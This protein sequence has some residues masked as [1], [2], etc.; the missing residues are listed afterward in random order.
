MILDFYKKIYFFI[1]VIYFSILLKNN[2]L[3][4]AEY[5]FYHLQKIVK[6]NQNVIDVGANIGRYSFKLSKLVGK[7][8][9]VYAFEPMNKSFLT[10]LALITFSKVKNILPFNFALSNKS[11]FVFMKELESSQKKNYIFGTQTESKIV[12]KKKNSI[13]KYC[14]ELDKIDIKKKISFIKIDCEGFELE[15]LQGSKR[16]IKKNKPIILFEYNDNK[17]VINY[18]KSLGYN[19]ILKKQKSRNKLFAH[20]KNYDFKKSI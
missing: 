20:K 13:V 8:G 18:L 10:F 5:E 2:K 17:K 1:G 19:E 15:V 12:N 4:S 7:N 9:L 3:V 6:K 14:I 11:N 16:L